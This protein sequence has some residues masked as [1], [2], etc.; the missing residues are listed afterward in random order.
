MAR[1]VCENIR[2]LQKS[3]RW[4]DMRLAAALGLPYMKVR[5]YIHGET[6]IPCD[7]CPAFALALN[8]DVG[9]LFDD[10]LTDEASYYADRLTDR[11]IDFLI[12]N[13]GAIS[14]ATKLTEIASE[15]HNGLTPYGSSYMVATP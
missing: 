6:S 14:C 1:K 12:D 4:S 13:D 10:K 9:V 5:R 7:I 2:I 15:F 8:V 3:Q 11:Q